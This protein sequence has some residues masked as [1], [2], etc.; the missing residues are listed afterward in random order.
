MIGSIIIGVIVVFFLVIIGLSCF[1]APPNKA[2]IVSGL[3]KEPRIYVGKI[4]IRIPF[5]ERVD[6][7]NLGV[8]KIDVKTKSSIPT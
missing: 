2:Y 4:G 8:I 7:L 3:R 5:L 6:K 1:I